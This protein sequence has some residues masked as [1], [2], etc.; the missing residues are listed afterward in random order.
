MA[1][2]HK[3]RQTFGGGPRGFVFLV[4]LQRWYHVLRYHLPVSAHQTTL[5][6]ARTTRA[7][8]ANLAA[9]TS[10]SAMRSVWARGCVCVGRVHRAV[11]HSPP[12]YA[13]QTH[14]PSTRPLNP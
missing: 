13:I 12:S 7:R 9:G 6:R 14:T 5:Y 1:A 2:I 11:Q 8:T 4:A 3:W 10:A